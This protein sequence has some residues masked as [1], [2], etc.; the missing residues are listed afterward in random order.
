[1]SKKSAAAKKGGEAK[2][3]LVGIFPIQPFVK[4]QDLRS[5]VVG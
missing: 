3:E 4:L 5:L 1:M 2:L